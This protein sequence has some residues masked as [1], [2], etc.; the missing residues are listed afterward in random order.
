[1]FAKK[2]NV[3]EKL[4]EYGFIDYDDLRS[5]YIINSFASVCLHNNNIE[6]LDFLISKE[7]KVPIKGINI[8][9]LGESSRIWLVNYMSSLSQSSA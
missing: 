4:L 6:S 3:I 8:D 2:L 5:H 7:I 1:M 9:K